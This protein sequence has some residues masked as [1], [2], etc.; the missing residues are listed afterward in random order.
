MAACDVTRIAK[1]ATAQRRAA[2][3]LPFA[4]V[5]ADRHNVPLPLIVAV[6]DTESRWNPLAVSNVGAVGLMQLMP[7]TGAQMFRELGLP[8]TYA[9]TQ[10]E[11]NIEMGT[12]LLMKLLARFNG[13]LWNATAAY[14]AGSGNV[15]KALASGGLTSGMRK[16]AAAVLGRYDIARQAC[17]GLASYPAPT[18]APPPRPS[19]PTSTRPS[20]SAP[21]Q[22]AGGGGLLLLALAAY[23]LS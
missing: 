16:Y 18:P 9:P 1:G 8:G 20:S 3:Y 21:A 12:H 17:S 2:A 10:P 22:A 15:N 23:Y 13:D 19:S 4:E 5:A 6:I 11:Q 7:R 14:W